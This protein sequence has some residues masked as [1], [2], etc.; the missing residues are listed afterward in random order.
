MPNIS[1]ILPIYNVDSYLRE[2]LD[3]I[4]NQTLKDIEIICVNDD[5]KDNSLSIMQE[6]AEKDSRIKIISKPN[7]GYGHT[8][9]VGIDAATGKYIG[10]VEPDD[11]VQ[12]DMYETLYNLAEKH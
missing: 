8:M 10:I 1:I 5:L 4:I 9:N 12:L 11:Y 7:S 2:C 3:S 6:H